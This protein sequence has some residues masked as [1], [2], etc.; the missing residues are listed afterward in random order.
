MDNDGS[1]EAKKSKFIH[2]RNIDCMLIDGQAINYQN[3]Q[4]KSF[5]KEECIIW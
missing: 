1:S 4:P 5:S 2:D 3:L